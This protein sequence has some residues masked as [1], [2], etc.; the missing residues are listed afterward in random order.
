M[1]QLWRTFPVVINRCISEKTT[2]P[3]RLR[4]SRAQI[5]WGMYKEK[6]FDYVALLWED[7]VYQA[8]KREIISAQK[9]HMSYPRF[10][11]VIINHFISKDKT[12][13]MRNKI[14]LHTSRNDSL[15]GTLK[16]VF[17]IEDSQKYGE[18]ILDG[19]INQDIKKSKAYKTYY[20]VVIRDT[21]GVSMS[22]KKKAPAKADRGKGIE[23]LYDVVL[24][25][26]A[27]LKKVHKKTKQDTHRLHTSGSSEGAN[28]K[29][30]VP[31][32]SKAKSSDTSEGTGVKPRVLNVSKTDSSKSDNESRGDSEEDNESDDNN[33]KCSK[34]DDDGGNDTQDSERTDA[35]ENENP[36]LNLNVDEE[37]TQEEKYVY[38]LDYYVPTDEG[39]ND[40][41]K[42]CDDE[43]YD[44]L[45]KDAN[46]R[47]KVTEHEEV[48]KGD[49][50]I[51]NTTRENGSQEKSYEQVVEDAHVTLTTSQKTKGSKQSS[52]AS[53]DFASKFLILDNVPPI[54]DEVASMMNVKVRYEESSTQAP[55]LLSVH[56][57]AILET[58]TVPTTMVPPTIQKFTPILQ[59]ST[60]TPEPTTKPTTTLIRALF[61]LS[62]LFGF[63]NRVSTLENELSQFKQVDHSAQ[64]LDTIKS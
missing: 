26:A 12:I 35:D 5:L 8:D 37:E 57:T 29:L 52:S 14:N 21:P 47:S 39:T 4:E 7:F 15:L 20:G 49:V 31:D 19:M 13:S 55:P 25:K 24:I 54:V 44:E 27:Q 33:D 48:R 50:E 43:E 40:E 63:D 1:H 11:K 58:S 30:E 10:T 16:F 18:L 17:K 51:T 23:L 9:K 59:Q 3:Y 60:P 42:E 2:R 61:D 22:K 34:N 56:V 45:Y 64:L 6:I 32:G 62:S 38:T 46:V 36:N 41:N 28:F 53:S